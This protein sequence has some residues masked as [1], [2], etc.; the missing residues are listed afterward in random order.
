M[1]EKLLYGFCKCTPSPVFIAK[2]EGG[3]EKGMK[4]RDA[5]Q[6]GD[7]S[8]HGGRFKLRIK[9]FLVLLFFSQK[10]KRNLCIKL[11]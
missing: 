4:V 2:S 11:F 7:M 6:G 1:T 10:I 5:I 9:V 3:E 8:V